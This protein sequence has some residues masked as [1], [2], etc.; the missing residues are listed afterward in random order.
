M[1]RLSRL[2]FR[3]ML[4]L[5][6]TA[7]LLLT[8]LSVTAETAAVQEIEIQEYQ[9]ERL[10]SV[11]DFRENSIAGVQ[12]LDPT[13]YRLVIDGL[14]S[15][16]MSLAL[17]QLQTMS[18]VQKLV[19]IDCVEGWSVRALWEG[20]PLA[21]LL[22]QVSPAPEANTLVFHAADGYTTSL[23]LEFVLDRGLIIADQ[24]NGIVLPPENGFPFQLVAEDKWGYKWIK[25]ITRIELSNDSSYRGFWERRGYSNEGDVDGPM[26]GN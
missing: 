4:P 20:I 19:T 14:V 16:S 10:G 22:E 9:G 2:S 11:N 17:A 24:I 6:M 15:Q 3:P 23:P 13:S 26:F 7:I 25:W 1:D 12:V 21:A 8:V 18:H 5:F